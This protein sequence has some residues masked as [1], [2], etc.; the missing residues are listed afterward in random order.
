MSISSYRN[1]G[2]FVFLAALFGISFVAIKAGL[3]ALPPVF[4]A[5]LRADVAAP[6]LLAY[7]AWRYE[8]WVPRS[9]ADFAS[10]VVGGVTLIAVNNALVF[11]GQQT[12]TP[13]GA[14]VLYGFNPI[15]APVFAYV[16]LDQRLDLLSVSGIVLGLVGVVIIVQ[17]SPETLLSGSTA[18]QLAVLG[19]A[20]SVAFGSVLLRRLDATIDSITLT[21]WSMVFG[22]VLLHA[23]S[24]ALGESLSVGSLMTPTIVAAVLVVGIPS[25]AIAY[26]IYFTLIGRIGPVRTNLVAYVAPVF[27]AITGWVLLGEGVSLATGVGF[28]VVVAGIGILER[29]VIRAEI[30]RL[31][32]LPD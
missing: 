4:F 27:A 5:A 21:A 8:S 24:A 25:T 23:G 28:L 22:A 12:L 2:L 6:G 32:S 14:S 9:R 30:K 13:A 18:G 11:V 1:A 16:L 3:A 10:V 17:P 7:V 20:L 31:D 19:A 15:L 29:H 26:P